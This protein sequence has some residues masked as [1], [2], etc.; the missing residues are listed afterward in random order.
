ME[1][2][3]SFAAN[4]LIGDTLLDH[5]STGY[6][7]MLLA[8]AVLRLLPHY[9]HRAARYL[10]A[11]IGDL[12]KSRSNLRQALVCFNGIF[13]TVSVWFYLIKPADFSRALI[14]WH[15]INWCCDNIY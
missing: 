4:G 6:S 14:S 9:C 12:Q 3:N 2:I 7:K 1:G 15:G 5:E 8:L 11:L 13:Y 10:I